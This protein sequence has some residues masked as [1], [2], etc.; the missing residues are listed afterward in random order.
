MSYLYT[1]QLLTVMNN[2]SRIPENTYNKLTI[3]CQSKKEKR[4]PF[5]LEMKRNS[6]CTISFEK[7]KQKR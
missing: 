2:P 6:I 4:R 7:S 5:H 1:Q 3:N